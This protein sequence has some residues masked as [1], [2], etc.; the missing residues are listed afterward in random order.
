MQHSI[1]VAR[2]FELLTEIH[3]KST[4][5]LHHVLAENVWSHRRPTDTT[6]SGKSSSPTGRRTIVKCLQFPCGLPVLAQLTSV[7]AWGVFRHFDTNNVCKLPRLVPIEHY[8]IKPMK[9]QTKRWSTTCTHLNRVRLTCCKAT[10]KHIHFFQLNLKLQK[11]D[12]NHLLLGTW[13]EWS[14]SG[15][16]SIKFHAFIDA[17][18]FKIGCD[19]FI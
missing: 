19:V 18:H 17:L 11:L 3:T 2:A 4:H 9:R 7:F 6:E 12:E 16:F 14:D 10:M 5:K 15:Q 13:M 8:T 1:W